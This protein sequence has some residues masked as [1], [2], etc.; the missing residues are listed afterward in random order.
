M[1]LQ[2]SQSIGSAM[3]K[4]L[5]DSLIRRETEKR[6][7][8]LDGLLIQ[9][10]NRRILK[11]E[12]EA[13]RQ[14]AQDQQRENAYLRDTAIQDEDRRIAAER[15]RIEDE[16]Y[17]A[18]QRRS[19][20]D[21]AD[22]QG[23]RYLDSER[24]RIEREQE[25][26]RRRREREEDRTHALRVVRE[27]MGG[28][29]AGNPTEGERNANSLYTAAMEAAAAVNTLEPEVDKLDWFQRTTRNSAPTWMQTEV[30]QQYR[31]AQHMWVQNVL[32]AESGAVIGPA[33]EASFIKTYFPQAGDTAGTRE[34]KARMRAVKEDAVR[35]K[36]GRAVAGNP[37]G[38][39]RS[40]GSK[41]VVT[42]R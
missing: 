32:R 27:Q 24:D 6:Q 5:R 14:A 40:G 12:N 28:K 17:E 33:E 29:A 37:G 15:Q 16:R 22:V 38:N 26:E 1:A 34:Q 30:M 11:E 13:R 9:D 8:L 35:L 36:A 18:G 20:M 19:A 42:V 41:Y 25:A 7:Q 31:Q 3:S 10:R 2:G 4:A 23:N 21:K 39:G